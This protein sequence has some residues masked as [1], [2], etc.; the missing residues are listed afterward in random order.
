M[1]LLNKYVGL[2]DQAEN[3]NSYEAYKELIEIIRV[4]TYEELHG[5]MRDAETILKVLVREEAEGYSVGLRELTKDLMKLGETFLQQ[6]KPEPLPPPLPRYT[7]EYIEQKDG[8]RG[9]TG[10]PNLEDS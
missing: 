9:S 10:T 4:A 6:T 3:L 1:T 8:V 5:W 7:Y 2:S